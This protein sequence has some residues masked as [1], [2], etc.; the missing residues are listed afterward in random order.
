[1]HSPTHEAEA[2]RTPLADGE[3]RRLEFDAS[4]ALEQF[5]GSPMLTEGRVNLIALDPIKTRL[6]D[7][8]P[9]R[10]EQVYEHVERV[11]ERNLGLT[12]YVVRVSDTDFLVAQ[13]SM[14][15]YAAQTACLRTLTELMRHFLGKYAPH[16][17]QVHR[18]T[19]LDGDCITGQPI[20]PVAAAEAARTEAAEL[21][22]SAAKAST[23]SLLSPERWSPF[24][25]GNGRRVRV[26]CR[27]EPVF[28]LKTNTRIGYRLH[29]R[30][31]DVATNEPLTP[32]EV[33]A[34]SRADLLRVD[35]AT[36]SRG[37]MRLS[38]STSREQELSLIIPVTH[39]SLSYQ[40]GRSLMAAAFAEARQ[41]VTRGVICEIADIED[42]PLVALTSAI[43]TIRP[44]SLL[45]MGGLYENPPRV[46]A[47]LKDAGF[48]ALSIEAAND[49]AGDAEFAGWLRDSLKATGRVTRATLVHGCSTM[50]RVGMAGLM[51]ATHAT[52]R[53]DYDASELGA[54]SA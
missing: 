3:I 29:R 35:M 32:A 22:A 14:G 42:I 8:W 19:A 6:A 46:T 20:D 31:I 24:V 40:Q 10:R 12:A 39:V 51:G 16:E 54:P 30:V 34:L 38:A 27:P 11:L 26:S 13:P 5:G 47:A 9:G 41:S 50:R 15:P 1:M 37:L 21:Q 45:I 25:A 2:T 33:L 52:L 49:A 53:E 48:Q 36:I 44:W 28:E 7:R 4:K 17:L 23:S 43:A 18:V